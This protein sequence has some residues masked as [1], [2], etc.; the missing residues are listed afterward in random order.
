MS[1][2]RGTV[3]PS[4][5]YELPR[6]VKGPT[7]VVAPGS[8]NR[9][10]SPG[11]PCGNPELSAT[12]PV[13]PLK[14]LSEEV[15][16][17]RRA[18]TE[19]ELRYVPAAQ[20]EHEPWTQRGGCTLLIGAPGSFK[21]TLLAALLGASASGGAIYGNVYARRQGAVYAIV[22]ED[23]SGWNARWMAWRQSA[24]IPEDVVLPLHTFADS[25]NLFTGEGFEEMLADVREVKPI[26]IGLD[27]LSDLITGADENSAKDMGR[28]RDR[29]K[30]L[31]G[32]DRSLMICQHTGWDE[33]RE[34]GSSV[35]RAFADTRMVMKATSGDVVMRCGKQRNK[36]AFAAVRLRFDSERH[37]LCAIASAVPSSA[38]RPGGASLRDIVLAWVCEHPAH[39]T[40][41]VARAIRRR[42]VDV[43]AALTALVDEGVLTSAKKG[44][45]TTW[46]AHCRGPGTVPL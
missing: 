32:S 28:V 13:A 23:L 45:A 22:G 38:P 41:A 14:R 46:S 30:L 24:G 15:P 7:T 36:A 25:V 44:N 27:P 10:T 4:L 42:K 2:G 6:V 31:M 19:R 35:F 29:C 5:G 9:G 3:A 18:L 39:A 37:V 43:I 12:R 8:E 21:S 11:T 20:W 40:D 17:R 16:A 26:V 34:R 1:T 33:S